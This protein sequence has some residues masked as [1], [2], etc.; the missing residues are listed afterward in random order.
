MVRKTYALLFTLLIND[1]GFRGLHP[2]LTVVRKSPE[3]GYKADDSLPSV[4]TCANYLKLPD[5]SNK[6]ILKQKLTI[7]MS[8]GKGFLLS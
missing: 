7:A 3:A 4:M 2:Q 1:T 6:D 5:Y 8:E